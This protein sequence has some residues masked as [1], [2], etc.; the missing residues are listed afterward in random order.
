M[1]FSSPPRD[2]FLR[3]KFFRH[4]NLFYQ[5]AV[6]D[7]FPLYSHATTAL[8]TVQ[9]WFKA[10]RNNPGDIAHASGNLL[11]SE[12]T[13][14]LIRKQLLLEKQRLEVL[15]SENPGFVLQYGEQLHNSLGTNHNLV[16]EY[17]RSVRPD[18]LFNS[19]IVSAEFYFTH[20]GN[21]PQ[22]WFGGSFEWWDLMEM[23]RAYG[24]ELPPEHQNP[25]PRTGLL[26]G[27]AFWQAVANLCHGR[28]FFP[29]DLLNESGDAAAAGGGGGGSSSGAGAGA[30]SG[31]GQGYLGG[32]SGAVAGPAA[33]AGPTIGAD[34]SIQGETN[35]PAAPET[36][37]EGGWWSSLTNAVA[38]MSLSDIVHT[39][40]DVVGLIPGLGEVADGLNALIYL[41][42][43]NYADAAL[44]AAAMIPG[45]GAAATAAKYAKKT[46]LGKA[47]LKGGKKVVS[48]VDNAASKVKNGL[49]SAKIKETCTGGCP[50]SMVTGEE[51]LQFTDFQ[52]PGRLPLA[53][54]RTY[55]TGHDNQ[56]GLGVGWTYT[57]CETLTQEEN[58]VVYHTDEARQVHLP[59]PA[60]GET[61]GQAHEQLLMTRP[62]EA[63]LILENNTGLQ[64]VFEK[65]AGAWRLRAYR[66]SD[67][68]EVLLSY[69]NGRLDRLTTQCGRAL[70]FHWSSANL[71]ERL[72]FL[73][74]R[75]EQEHGVMTYTYNDAR[76]LVANHDALELGERYRYR[77][78]V[79]VQ[80]TLRTGFSYYFEWDRYDTQARCLHNWGDDG[81]YDVRFAWFPE[82]QRSEITDSRGHTIQYHYNELGQI[83]GE[84]DPT[85]AETRYER[86]ALGAVTKTTKPSGA[87][88]DIRYDE[89]GRILQKTN[90]N[91]A[92]TTMAYNETGD[93]THFTDQL[94][95]VWRRIYNDSR[96]VV[97]TVDPCGNRSTIEY[98]EQGLPAKLTRADGTTMVLAWNA[99]GELVREVYPDRQTIDYDYDDLGRVVAMQH[100]DALTRY[101]YDAVGRLTCV[102]YPD[103]TAKTFGYHS[104]DLINRIVDENGNV[105][106]LEYADGLNQI[107]KR[108]NADGSVVCYEYDRERNM[109]ALVN[110]RGERHQ[111]IYDANERV[112]QEI[113]FD[114]RTQYYDYD[115]DG[116]LVSHR[117]DGFVTTFERD[118]V[119]AL[120]RK[121]SRDANGGAPDVTE[122]A[123]DA[124]GKLIKADNDHRRLRFIYDPL[125]RMIEEWQDNYVSSH[126]F[127][128]VGNRLDFKLP[129]GPTL[130]YQ[131]DAAG[132][133]IGTWLDDRLLALSEYDGNGRE[134]VRQL[135]N[136][137]E[138]H[139][140]FD[141]NGR[142]Q[143]IQVFNRRGKDAGPVSQRRYAYDPAGAL[144][145]VDDQMRGKSRF[146]YDP[147]KQLKQ[148][149]GNVEQ[150]FYFDPTGNPIDPAVAEPVVGNR[151]RAFKGKRYQYDSR[152][153]L[154]ERHDPAQ[155]ERLQFTYGPDNQLRRVERDG[156]V[157]EYAYDALGRRVS[158]RKGQRVTAFL[159]DQHAMIA[160]SQDGGHWK[161]FV[162][163]QNG[164]TPLAMIDGDR[165]YYYHNDHLGTPQELTDDDGNCVW[166]AQYLAYGG[167]HRYLV[168]QVDNPLRF[169]GQYYDDETGLHYNRY[170]YYDPELGRF[171]HQDPLSLLGGMNA[172][173][174]APNPVNWTDPLG[175]TCKEKVNVDAGTAR[176]VVAQDS[177]VRHE[178]KAFVKDKEMVM[179]QT[180][181]DEFSEALGRLGGAK[182]KARGK[183]FLDRVTVIPD[184]PS[185]RVMNLKPTKRIKPPDQ[186]VFGT[187]DKMGITTI[188]SDKKFPA[189]AADRGFQKDGAVVLDVYVHQPFS[190]IGA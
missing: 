62:N 7:L 13:D 93:P 108:I 112:I 95:R 15:L 153:N 138:E 162:Y 52:L 24:V 104:N 47:M 32:D 171:I 189:S 121:V 119:G 123:Y 11:D 61:V 107:T 70:V 85:G 163:E 49:P 148:V 126:T 9:R 135:G 141:I 81:N 84:T 77:N 19:V 116:F 118:A 98:N 179:T 46:G 26:C 53:F 57:G 132:T 80:R 114:G 160:E 82:Q 184:D 41:A 103:G 137:L 177:P 10:M 127:D 67:G 182:E 83:I 21:A 181:H 27:E 122:Y 64:R 176:A 99:R 28:V 150:Q 156:L 12:F 142:L 42:E 147:R 102:T 187:G 39:T 68:A 59:L 149:L 130:R 90:A 175:L 129:T 120:L 169:P 113:G 78:H 72:G 48:K 178:I 188:T 159:W 2:A 173:A 133:R 125:G 158:K 33:P 4:K 38:N 109:T 111:I 18:K 144:T 96:Q 164:E 146:Q 20:V 87:T 131:N 115:A 94:G 124:A 43:G 117:E 76:D 45:A 63:T 58:G 8:D 65:G 161:T 1:K 31:S 17:A 5:H 110:E 89:F 30:G 185:D 128:A 69:R 75:Q 165:F 23:I 155:Q 151:I 79:L 6:P 50:I 186:N 100:G 97:A 55:R 157:T 152:G 140:D 101:S 44:S 35:P 154:T 60:V 145:E 29:L 92:L 86:N 174:Y 37:E 136:Q 34:G 167:V 166:A 134:R 54:E 170:R 168:E 40:L 22:Q 183:K 88:H 36:E 16:T 3:N 105:T 73:D 66:K 106:R 71:I 180:A 143:R 56:T 74:G 139:N 25:V 14:G 91:G 190:F 172:Y 51:L